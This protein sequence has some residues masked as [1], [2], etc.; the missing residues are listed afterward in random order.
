MR[1]PFI[2]HCFIAFLLLFSPA[3]AELEVVKLD[4]GEPEGGRL[5]V[6]V[7][8]RNGGDE[9]ISGAVCEFMAGANS[10]GRLEDRSSISPGQEVTLDG[11]LSIP[12]GAQL[13]KEALRVEVAPYRVPDLAIEKVELPEKLT[14]GG[15]AECIVWV[16]NQ[17]PGEAPGFEVEL[18]HE[19]RLLARK[20]QVHSLASD[21]TL[22]IRLS[23][24]PIGSGRQSLRLR[25]DPKQRLQE[26]DEDNNEKT[27]TVVLESAGDSL[28]EVASFRLITNPLRVEAPVLALVEV[29]H[30]GDSSISKIPLVVRSDGQE[31]KSQVF[32]KRLEPGAREQFRITFLPRKSGK[33]LL[34]IGLESDKPETYQRRNTQ[35]IEVEGRPTPDLLMEA[36]EMPEA[37]RFGQRQTVVATVVNQGDVAA[38]ACRVRLRLGDKALTTSE[39]FDVAA[40]RTAQL[41]L[42]WVPNQ[43]GEL[44]LEVEVFSLG[45]LAESE[46]DNN[47]QKATIRVVK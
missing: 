5:P 47:R 28:L 37:V 18:R 29:V 23:F 17:G 7:W 42:E 35:T 44:P 46:L 40:G 31:L 10:W 1:R 20:L 38:R 12:E 8:I 14:S 24:S 33:Q 4:Y 3:W 41:K 26:S 11:S 15:L 19:G 45:R 6:R 36:F 27:V 21:R 39:S 43:L 22:P 13:E 2:F 30:R 34:T 9:P 32:Y 25:L 16:R